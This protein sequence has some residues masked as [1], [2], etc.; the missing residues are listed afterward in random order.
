MRID[1]VGAILF[2]GAGI[3]LLLALNWGSPGEWSTAR[4]IA[5]FVVSGVLYIAWV[6]GEHLLER[7]AESGRVSRNPLMNTDPMIPLALFR[8]FNLCVTQYAILVSGMVMLVMFY[9][10][11]IFFTIVGGLSGTDAGTQLLYFAPGLGGGSLLSM[12]M[13]RRL[14]QPKFPIVLG[15]SIIPIALGLVSWAIDRNNKGEVNG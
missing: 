10:V 2:M 3:T 9:F 15:S 4:V 5:C 11:A 12:V 8:S 14:R 7:K 6:I 1:W 13:V